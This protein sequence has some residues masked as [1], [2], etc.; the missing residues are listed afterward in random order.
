MNRVIV[1]VIASFALAGCGIPTETA[2]QTTAPAATGASPSSGASTAASTNPAGPAAVSSSAATDAS[3]ATGKGQP[4]PGQP[5]PAPPAPAPPATMQPVPAPT[6]VP[7]PRAVFNDQDADN[8]GGG[9]VPA[10]SDGDGQG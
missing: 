6:A 5:A 2:T 1:V 3:T 9:F 4:L 8:V 7:T 10:R